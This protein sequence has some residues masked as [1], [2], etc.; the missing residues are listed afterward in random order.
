MAW[1]LAQTGALDQAADLLNRITPEAA[2]TADKNYQWWAVIVGFSG[3][4]D[5]VGTGSGPRSCT[6]SPLP[7]PGATARWGVAYLGAA[8][9]WLGVLAGVTGRFTDAASHLEA[10]LGGTRTWGRGH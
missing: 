8:D 9:H 5:L 3:A 1:C 7:M 2:A 10:A 6:I 4:V